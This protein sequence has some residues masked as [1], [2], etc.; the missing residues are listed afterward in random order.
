[1]CCTLNIK[2]LI[3]ELKKYIDFKFDK[4]MYFLKKI[5]KTINNTNNKFKKTVESNN[6]Q[7]NQQNLKMSSKNDKFTNYQYS[8][9]NFILI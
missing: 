2:N 4:T 8:L 5:S 7:Q 9:K 3:N 6:I 1:M